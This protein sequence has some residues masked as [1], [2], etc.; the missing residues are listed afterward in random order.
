MVRFYLLEKR[1]LGKNISRVSDYWSEQHYVLRSRCVGWDAR[2][3]DI[4]DVTQ[5]WLPIANQSCHMSQRYG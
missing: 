5:E 2:Y 1:K 4:L 3:L